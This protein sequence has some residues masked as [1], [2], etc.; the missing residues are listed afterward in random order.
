MDETTEPLIV[1]IANPIAGN[2]TQFAIERAL[3][4]MD[5]DWRVISFN[6]RPEDVAAALEGFLVTGII[7]VF[8]DPSLEDEASAWYA[9][10]SDQEDQQVDCLFREDTD[11][12]NGFQSSNERL[13]WIASQSQGTTESER[14]WFGQE[15]LPDVIGLVESSVEPPEPCQV[16]AAK[17]VVITQVHDGNAN[18]ETADWPT[19]DGSTLVLDLTDGHPEQSSLRELGYRVLTKSDLYIGKLQRCLARWTHQSAP[20]D[21]IHDAI[22]EYF[23]V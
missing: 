15:P 1:V 21:V 12:A 9:E 7:G 18:L 3:N 17:L 23:G 2:P 16:E 6:V 11:D 10:K 4:A 5:L 8:I 22:E 14:L 20:V 19:D 13:A